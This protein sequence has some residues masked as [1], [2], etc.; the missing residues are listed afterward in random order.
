[1]RCAAFLVWMAAL[2]VALPAA[3][4]EQIFGVGR[5]ERAG[6]GAV[7]SAA[8]IAPDLVVTAAHCVRVGKDGAE[9]APA[10]AF[11]PG[12]V[13]GAPPTTVDEVVQH[14]LFVFTASKAPWSLRFD[15]ALLRLEAEV[16]PSIA[17]PLGLGVEAKIGEPLI[18][19]S[20]RNDGTSR[21]RQRACEVLEN[22][23]SLVTVACPV[24]GGE[25][26]SPIIRQTAAGL[27]IV[28]V[29]S[30]RSQMGSQPVGLG[31]NLNGRLRP[32]LDLL[33]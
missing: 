20:W 16:P 11:R 29:L 15:L 3:A 32:M 22:R 5:L 12:G 21:P 9:D 31:S 26:G 23:P 4:S 1:M 14:P 2:A 10:L 6:E 8:L 28:A 24:R 30:S 13:V 18:I 25:S 7:C 19:A 27:E 33:D 17:L